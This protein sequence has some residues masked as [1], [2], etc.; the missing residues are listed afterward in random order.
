MTPWLLGLVVVV[1]VAAVLF[2]RA[3]RD[4][5]ATS[6]ATARAPA[7]PP[8]APA[9]PGPPSAPPKAAAKPRASAQDAPEIESAR[10]YLDESDDT[11]PNPWVLVSGVGRTDAGLRRKH[12][13]DAFLVLESHDL[14]VVADGMGRHQAGEIASRMAVDTVAATFASGDFGKQDVAGSSRE[15]GRLL[16]AFHEANRAV[17]DASREREEYSG[18]GTTMVALH[19]SRGKDRA[20]ICHAGDSRCYRSRGGTLEQ[21][22]V[23]HTL[24]A[25]GIVGPSANVL[26]RAVGIEEN[27][28]PDAQTIKP[29]VGDIFLICSDGLS[30]MVQLPEIQAVLEREHDLD[31]AASTLIASANAAGGRDNVTV[32]LV[33]VDK[34]PAHGGEA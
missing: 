22:T 30:R 27:L 32:I 11:Q 17:F 29:E 25:A 28:E 14:F 18:M 5:G 10:S 33:R 24:G 21:L 34:S 7:P 20:A 19:F 9:T 13:E 16:A 26:S 3:R 1:I 8:A 2:A 12:N 31:A 4:G 23:D 6:N 15:A